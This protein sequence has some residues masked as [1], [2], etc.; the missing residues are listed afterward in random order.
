MFFLAAAGSFAQGLTFGFMG[1]VPV[2]ALL[3]SQPPT[4]GYPQGGLT[5]NTM[6]RYLFGASVGWRF[7]GGFAVEAD[8][9]HRR[10]HYEDSL[11]FAELFQTESEDVSAGDWEFP[12]Q[13]KYRLPGSAVRPYISAGAALDVL[14]ASSSFSTCCT[15]YY[16]PYSLNTTISPGG[17]TTS[18]PFGLQRRSVAGAVVG[19]GLDVQCGPIHILPEARYTHWTG[20]HFND[21]IEKSNQNQVEFLVGISR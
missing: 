5:S 12:L 20:E 14:T 18:A 16:N 19:V 9:L 11:T 1:G 17:G 13:V 10:L 21:F 8:A 2:T 3:N 15:V 6:D 7:R 4:A